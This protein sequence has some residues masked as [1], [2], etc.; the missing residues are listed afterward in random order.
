MGCM[1]PVVKTTVD[2]IQSIWT[3]FAAQAFFREQSTRL[4]VDCP[5]GGAVYAPDRSPCMRSGR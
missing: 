2:V 1:L 3:A 4:R 5:L